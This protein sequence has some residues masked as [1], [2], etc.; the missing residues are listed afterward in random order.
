[1]DSNNL[2]NSNININPP[3]YSLIDESPNYY[4]NNDKSCISRNRIFIY[5]TIYT[6]LL[7]LFLILIIFLYNKY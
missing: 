5:K 4:I 1:M 6:I 3:P 7:I 2:I